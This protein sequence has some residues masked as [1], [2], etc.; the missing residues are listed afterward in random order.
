MTRLTPE[1]LKEIRELT[2]VG[3]EPACALELLAEIDAL[4]SEN[5]NLLH[6]NRVQADVIGSLKI[7]CM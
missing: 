4:K 7:A 3:N 6:T 1:R 5:E 2:E